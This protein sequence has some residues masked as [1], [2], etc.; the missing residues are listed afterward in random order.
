MALAQKPDQTEIILVHSPLVGPSSL[1]PT[2]LILEQ[3]GF[4]C[5]VPSPYNLA[6]SLPT[7]SEW[8]NRLLESLSTISSSNS[9]IV[10]H[11]A[12]GL[13]AAW[14]A[15]RWTAKGVVF[16]DAMIPPSEGR[17][18][19][20]E[21]WFYDFVHSLPQENSLLPIWTQW[22]GKDLLL[23]VAASED[24]KTLFTSELPRI[25]IGWFD[26]AFEMTDWSS[27]PAGYVQT[28]S[29]FSEQAATAESRQ[30]PVRRIDGTHL[31]PALA[32]EE[33]AAALLE[34]CSLL[35]TP[36]ISS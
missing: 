3:H 32:P 14:L 8:P 21:P 22:W 6:E 15:G 30:W 35:A 33:T 19:P 2:A 7:W 28:S 36:T 12:G 13:L 20:A 34:V 18:V 4:K 25:P 27:V 24:F 9:I 5:H 11:S 23:N 16:L 10:G 26:D 29:V 17:T 1:A 31:H